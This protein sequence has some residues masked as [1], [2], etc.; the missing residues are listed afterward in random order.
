[1]ICTVVNE[2]LSYELM[3]EW[4]ISPALFWANCKPQLPGFPNAY[5]S[6]LQSLREAH[7]QFHHRSD[8]VAPTSFLITFLTTEVMAQKSAW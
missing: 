8:D 3:Q 5:K 2:F 4:F 1:M 7:G 6:S